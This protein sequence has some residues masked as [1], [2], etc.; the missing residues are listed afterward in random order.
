MLWFL[1]GLQLD[2][3]AMNMLFVT[4][5]TDCCVAIVC[6]LLFAKYLKC[7]SHRRK[8]YTL[9]MLE[10]MIVGSIAAVILSVAHDVSYVHI[11]LGL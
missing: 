11:Y 9:L 6:L 8:I 10:V 2:Q 3:F 7:W 4:L 1:Y 5:K